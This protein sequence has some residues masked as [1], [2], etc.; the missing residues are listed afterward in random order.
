MIFEVWLWLA[1]AVI[2]AVCILQWRNRPIRAV[3]TTLI[4]WIPLFWCW[5]FALI[6]LPFGAWRIPVGIADAG[7]PGW[8]PPRWLF[9]LWALSVPLALAALLTWA[10]F[11]KRV[12]RRG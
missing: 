1:V 10:G 7:R 6:F 2:G 12:R 3:G 5:F 9:D 4:V 8:S 11:F